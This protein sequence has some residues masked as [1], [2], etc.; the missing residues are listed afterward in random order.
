MRCKS[1]VSLGMLFFLVGLLIPRPA[2][3]QIVHWTLQQNEA[4]QRTKCSCWCGGSVTTVCKVYF[5][6]PS[7]FTSCYRSFQNDCT[8]SGFGSACH[9]F[10][11]WCEALCEQDRH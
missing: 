5:C 2:E 6:S 8:E 3:A 10:Y 9:E 7:L 1:L 11:L 4:I